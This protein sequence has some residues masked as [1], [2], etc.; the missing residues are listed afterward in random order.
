[1][2]HA[3]FFLLAFSAK[4]ANYFSIVIIARVNGLLEIW[5]SMALDELFPGSLSRAAVRSS[6]G[7]KDVIQISAS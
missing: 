2:N 7:A 1:M 6:P 5:L 3:A 4:R